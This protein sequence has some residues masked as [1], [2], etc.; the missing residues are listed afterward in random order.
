MNRFRV[1]LHP[2]FFKNPDAAPDVQETQELNLEHALKELKKPIMQEFETATNNFLTAVNQGQEQEIISRYTNKDQLRSDQKRFF[3]RITKD[4][5][6]KKWNEKIVQGFWHLIEELKENKYF[7]GKNVKEETAKIKEMY[8]DEVKQQYID[9]VWFAS[10]KKF[11]R[12]RDD[13]FWRE[14]ANYPANK[15]YCKLTWAT[16][17]INVKRAYIEWYNTDVLESISLD[18]DNEA[19]DSMSDRQNRN[20]LSNDL[21]EYLWDIRKTPR[22]LKWLAILPIF[23]VKEDR[24]SKVD[25][26]AIKQ[27]LKVSSKIEVEWNKDQATAL[28][29]VLHDNKLNT[30]SWRDEY[31]EALRRHGLKVDD[32]YI[33]DIV[34]V[35]SFYIKTQTLDNDAKS[36]H[37]IYLSVL[38]AI[39]KKGWVEN[40]VS[41]FKPI[42][43]QAEK[44]KKAEKKEWY[45]SGDLLSDDLRELAKKLEMTDLASVTRLCKKELSYFQKTSIENIIANLNNDKAINAMDSITGWSKTGMQFLEIFRE[46]SGKIWEDAILK[47]LLKRAKLNNDSLWLGL[48]GKLF[49]LETAKENIRK[50]HFGLILLLQ[51]IISRPGTDLH[52]LLSGVERTEKQDLAR[53]EAEWRIKEKAFIEAW[54]ILKE[55]A[56]L[57]EYKELLKWKD[58]VNIQNFADLQASLAS[59]LYDNYK[60]GIWVWSTL[61][62]EDWAKWLQIWTWAQVRGDWVVLWLSVSYNKTF[63]VWKGWTMTPGLSAWVFLPI[64]S[65]KKDVFASA[66]LHLTA[67]KKQIKLDTWTV[68]HYGFDAWFNVLTD[69][70]YLWWHDEWNRAEWIDEAAKFQGRKFEQ[71]IMWNLLDKIKDKT[72]N[73]IDITNAKVKEIIK[74]LVDGQEDIKESDKENVVNGMLRML[75]PY[76]NKDL[77]QPWVKYAI[78]EWVAEQYEHSWSEKRKKDITKNIYLSWYGVWAFWVVWTPVAGAYAQIYATEHD[79]DGYGDKWWKEY[80]IDHKYASGWTT[81]LIKAFNQEAWFEKDQ[82]LKVENGFVII[83]KSLAH[84]VNVNKKLEWKMKKDKDWNI[85]LHLQTPMAAKRQ[86][87]AAS[88][89]KEIIIWW[90]KWEDFRKLDTVW[91]S[92]FTSWN[93]DMNDVL[94]LEEGIDIYSMEALNKVLNELK[95]TKLSW[96]PIQNFDFSKLSSVE[97]QGLINK[98]KAVEKGKKVR[99]VMIT[100][101]KWELS[102]NKVEAWLNW[103]W[104]EIDYKSNLDMIDQ[105]AKWIATAVY[106]EA[107]K[108]RNPKILNSVKH[109]KP[110]HRPEYDPFRDAMKNKDYI[111]A[112]ETIKPIFAKLDQQI[113]GAKFSEIWKK[114]DEFTN[115]KKETDVYAL[116]QALMSINNIFARSVK[117]VWWSSEYRFTTNMWNIIKEREGQILTT[118]QDY[119]GENITPEVKAWYKSLIEASAKYRE[120]NPQLFNKMSAPAAQ[121]RNTVWFNLWDRANPENPL[122]NPEIYSPMVDLKE[123]ENLGFDKKAKNKLHERA[124]RLFAN[125]E[126]LINPIKKV[127][128][129]EGDFQIKEFNTDW[130]KWKLTL[131]IK[132]KNGIKREVILSAWMEFGYFTQCVN[133]TVMLTDISV[134]TDDGAHLDFNSSVWEET[135]QTEW[136]KQSINSSVRYGTGFSVTWGK[137]ERKE[138]KSEEPKD[139]P[140]SNPSDGK[141]GSIPEQEPATWDGEPD[142]IRTEWSHE[143]WPAWNDEDWL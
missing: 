81:D 116:W 119:D 33:D 13:L 21:P 58:N 114:L 49:D 54:K 125:N 43:E 60:L 83:P 131:D 143:G 109:D 130:E 94:E 113:P 118:I 91:S 70:A 117:V 48:E 86:I 69:T 8:W 88:Q 99:I 36:Q 57:E 32:K 51:N 105:R 34:K 124:M 46:V 80:G 53:I 110:R 52:A 20:F 140:R 37:A 123:L 76:N 106:A 111:T 122:F 18:N 107:L 2:A 112:R 24:P 128:K 50:G 27:F 126:A 31:K 100:N 85:L 63:N 44:D 82:W 22:M 132:D 5:Y 89:S 38:T 104:V 75:A 30:N 42:V 41:Y 35:W 136:S 138:N 74:E 45:E 127:L 102:I 29:E 59:C 1:N 9:N 142:D 11:E 16:S 87:G 47:N 6:S 90:K 64:V 3:E 15:I 4:E 98:M 103:R 121:L 65:W 73:K 56:F 79:L 137:E 92:W 93:I 61:S 66:W 120:K 84:I 115:E 40:A 23:S 139:N 134:E 101:E 96:D 135:T 68:R 72:W 25:R 141:P 97:Q 78:A 71:V 55:K 39:E 14:S 95:K 7:K 108:L 77:S 26:K 67:D 133:H 19:T 17:I 28:M 62:F 129:L 10:D 12:V